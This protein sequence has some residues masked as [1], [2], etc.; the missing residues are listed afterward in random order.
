MGATLSQLEMLYSNEGSNDFLLKLLSTWANG[1]CDI[2]P[3]CRLREFAHCHARLSQ[4]VHG[5]AR[6]SN[7]ILD[8]QVV[9]THFICLESTIHQ[10]EI[11]I[12]FYLHV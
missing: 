1:L 6:T 9:H 8:L 12:H 10:L 11:V 5:V 3:Q 4:E 2:T 7:C